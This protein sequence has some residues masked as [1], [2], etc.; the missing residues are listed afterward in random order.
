M[1]GGTLFIGLLCLF[2]SSLLWNKVGYR[3]RPRIMSQRLRGLTAT[4]VCRRS[5]RSWLQRHYILSFLLGGL[6][7]CAT[8]SH[9]SDAEEGYRDLLRAVDKKPYPSMEG[10]RNIQRL[11]KSYNPLVGNVRMENLVDNHFFK[12]LDE[13]GFIDHLY[14]AYGVK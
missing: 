9:P 2:L 12:G 13:S 4:Y 1:A 14:S 8:D 11:M 6:V 7:F 10:L 5:T 3:P